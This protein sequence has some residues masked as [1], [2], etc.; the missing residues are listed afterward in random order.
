MRRRGGDHVHEFGLVRRGHDRHVRQAAEIREVE[1]ARV[2]RPVGDHEACAIDR[3]AHRQVLDGDVVHHL[4]VAALQE[5]RIDRAERLAA[6]PRQARGE[7]HRMLLGDAHVERRLGNASPKRSSPVP[8][9]IAA[10]IATIFS[11]RCASCEGFLQTRACRTARWPSA[12]TARP[13]PRRTCSRR[14]TCPPRLPPADS[15]CPSW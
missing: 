1:R 2:R 6:L 12:S 10:V 5:R 11:S 13:L 3:E 9:G 7:G 4:V 8:D 15:P 14:D